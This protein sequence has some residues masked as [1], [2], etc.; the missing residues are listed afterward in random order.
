MVRVC[1]VNKLLHDSTAAACT[2]KLILIL[3]KRFAENTFS[4]AT[5]KFACV[6]LPNLHF[7]CNANSCRGPC[8]LCCKEIVIIMIILSFI[9]ALISPPLVPAMVVIM[10][11]V[12]L[13]IVALLCGVIGAL[14][15]LRK[16]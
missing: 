15:W 1:Y 11:I 9:P 10:M 16:K 14:H 2:E 13:M 6:H 8:Y 4:W 5:S 7:K 3:Q 12:V